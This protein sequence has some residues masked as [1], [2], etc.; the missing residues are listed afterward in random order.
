MHYLKSPRGLALLLMFK[1]LKLGMVLWFF[2]GGAS[3]PG[4]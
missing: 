2:S 3:T 4:Q 1:M